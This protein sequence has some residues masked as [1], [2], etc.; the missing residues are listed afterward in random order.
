VGIANATGL[1]AGLLLVKKKSTMERFESDK[2]IGLVCRGHMFTN[3]MIMR[4]VGDRMI[5]APPFVITREQIDMMIATI[6]S[7]LDATL[8]DAKSR[9]WL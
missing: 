7:C 9:G 6:R 1:M 3:G 4:H 8:A 2:P 5:I